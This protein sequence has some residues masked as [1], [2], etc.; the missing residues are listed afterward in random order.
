MPHRYVTEVTGYD[1]YRSTAV[2]SNAILPQL[3]VT[4]K[5]PQVLQ[6]LPFHLKQQLH[7]GHRDDE[8]SSSLGG[9]K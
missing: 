3:G 6:N 9:E 2:V 8:H 1:G 5:A 4:G 7:L